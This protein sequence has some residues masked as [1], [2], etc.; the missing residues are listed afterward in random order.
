[1]PQH[2]RLNQGKPPSYSP[3]VHCSVRGRAALVDHRRL[4]QAT[5]V[6]VLSYHVARRE[7]HAIDRTIGHVLDVDNLLHIVVAFEDS[8]EDPGAER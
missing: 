6:Q 4:L 8:P 5:V 1:M 2:D 3:E 7:R